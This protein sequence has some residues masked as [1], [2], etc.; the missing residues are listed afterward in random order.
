MYWRDALTIPQAP[1]TPQES[2][3]SNIL[4]PETAGHV[5]VLTRRPLSQ[6][7]RRHS[8][9]ERLRASLHWCQV[10]VSGISQ[11]DNHAEHYRSLKWYPSPVLYAQEKNGSPLQV[12]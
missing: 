10:Q 1:G 3:I 4:L 8:S 6:T 12:T 5:S 2:P 11:S 9:A 7:V